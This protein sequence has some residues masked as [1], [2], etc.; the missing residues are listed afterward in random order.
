MRH[1]TASQ[2]IARLEQRIA[3]L[4]RE[5][6]SFGD[7]GR[8]VLEAT[9]EEVR[10]L[11]VNRFGLKASPIKLID[12]GQV[13]SAT[14]TLSRSFETVGTLTVRIKRDRLVAFITTGAITG[15]E[16]LGNVKYFAMDS[17]TSTEALI[18]EVK[19]SLRRDS[20]LDLFFD[21]NEL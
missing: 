1:L 7:F 16:V 21:I 11:V 3:K 5:A 20:S 17:R 10:G 4:E 14:S 19:E 18:K 15:Y 6:S 2:K 13:R 8:D 9:A 12:R